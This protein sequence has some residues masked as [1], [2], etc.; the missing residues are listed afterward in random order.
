[1]IASILSVSMCMSTCISPCD[2]ASIY[3]SGILKLEGT[4]NLKNCHLL[5]LIPFRCEYVHVQENYV[6]FARIS[7]SSHTEY[8]GEVYVK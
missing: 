3:R 8:R 4:C 6:R 2:E 1:M 7:G 5:E